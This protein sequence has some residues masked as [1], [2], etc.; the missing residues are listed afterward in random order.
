MSLTPTRL[1][2]AERLLRCF[3]RMIWLG[4]ALAATAV[5]GGL[6]A[7]GSARAVL[8]ALSLSG[9]LFFAGVGFTLR[10]RG[11]RTL[12]RLLSRDDDEGS[13]TAPK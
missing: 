7:R 1:P 2:N 11:R 6:V 8:L 13:E 9:A 10:L 3:G 5:V 4:A 12:D